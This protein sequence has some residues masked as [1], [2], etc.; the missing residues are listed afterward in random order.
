[1][2][3][4]HFELMKVLPPQQTF[5]GV[6]MCNYVKLNETSCDGG[7]LRSAYTNLIVYD[8]HLWQCDL[9]PQIVL[10]VVCILGKYM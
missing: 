3:P 7:Q 1:M 2:N 9:Q 10:Q 8:F 4:D 5:Q 6:A